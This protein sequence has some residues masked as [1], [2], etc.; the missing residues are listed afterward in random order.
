M[1]EVHVANTFNETR[2]LGGLWLAGSAITA[3]PAYMLLAVS[4]LSGSRVPGVVLLVLTVLGAAL[5]IRLFARPQG[6][7]ALG[8]SIATSVVWLVG[9]VVVTPLME[10]KADALWAGGGPAMVALVT[11]LAAW[12]L[13]RAAR[14]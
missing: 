8:L 10:F 13:C 2:M 6:G 3:V 12:W 1:S 11:G 14:R 9:A 5:G 7:T 4:D